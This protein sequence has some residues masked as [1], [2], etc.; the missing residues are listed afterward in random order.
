MDT[1]T[2]ES[3]VARQILRRKWA[4]L[5]TADIAVSDV[6]VAREIRRQDETADVVYA[7]FQPGA[8]AEDIEISA[9]DLATY[10]GEQEERYS[11]G[12][13]RAFDLVVF[14]RL[15]TQSRTE[16]SEEEARAQYDASLASRFTLPEQRRASHILIKT[17]SGG[18]DSDYQDARQRAA[19]ALARVRNGEDFAAVASELSE[20]ATAANGGDLGFF[21]R[22]VMTI[23]F[24]KAVWEMGKAGDLSDVVQ[25]Q[26]GYHVIQ[27]TGIQEAYLKSFEEVRDELEQEITFTKAGDQVRLDAE[28]F[29]GAVRTNP[30]GF[31]DETARRAIVS[32]NSGVVHQGEAIMGIGANPEVDRALFTLPLGEVS[33]PLPIAR[34]YLVARFRESS[35]GGAP[36]LD[37]IRGTVESD[38]RREKGEAR[39]RAR[40]QEVAAAAGDKGLAAL[41]EQMGFTT[42]S[43]PA[44]R[45]GSPVGTLSMDPAL[46]AAIF[47]AEVN[48][49]QGPLDLPDGPVVFTV[50]S[51]VEIGE[52]EIQARAPEVRQTLLAGRRQQLLSAI[53]RE[54]SRQA[55]VAYN[56]A[57]IQQMD[58]PTA[59]A[60]DS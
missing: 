56:T 24:E 35:P 11:R 38:L 12:E 44:L 28:E 42:E 6:Q 4:Q 26:F 15:R 30:A 60:S 48:R 2:Y 25:T 41:G 3:G 52:E 39:A 7:Q 57:L 27:L 5:L 13:G 46:E 10:Y 16:V 43:A 54:L 32:S 18:Q 55:D 36:P 29:A 49:V 31:L 22:G 34:G 50:T 14:D 47:S 1:A 9:A 19:A 21:P 53:T 23:P 59:A 40:A 33:G 51:R 8:F 58:D 17:L 45:H 37:E 20:D